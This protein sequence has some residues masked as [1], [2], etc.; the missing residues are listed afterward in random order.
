MEQLVVVTAR[1]EA[2]KTINIAG[3]KTSMS[4]NRFEVSCQNLA[5]TNDQ[6]LVKMFRDWLKSRR[7]E[8]EM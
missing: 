2:E 6:V 5:E 8:Y 1:I 3:V 4:L 7:D